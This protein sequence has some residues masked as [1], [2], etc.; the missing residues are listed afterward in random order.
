M[1]EVYE[2]LQAHA[3][4]V[5]RRPID[6]SQI[7]WLQN[8]DTVAMLIFR[9]ERVRAAV[10]SNEDYLTLTSICAAAKQRLVEQ[11]S[12][13]DPMLTQVLGAMAWCESHQENQE[14]M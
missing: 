4:V 8:L 3:Q 2:A 1:N 7:P 10:I 5:E 6:M 13:N 12:T 14:A 11:W 9:S